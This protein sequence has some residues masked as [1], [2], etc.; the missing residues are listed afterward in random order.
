MNKSNP[1]ES[2]LFTLRN[3]QINNIS[4]CEN[5]KCFIKSQLSNDIVEGPF[6][7]GVLQGNLAVSFRSTED[8][9]EA[10]EQLR[11]G[12]NTTLWCDGM[13][14]GKKKRSHDYDTDN[15]EDIEKKKPKKRKKKEDDREEKVEKLVEGLKA[16]HGTTYTPIQFRIWAEMIAG[17]VHI[18]QDEPPHTTFFNLVL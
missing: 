8:I 5:L 18:S 12:K 15:E 2:K 13:A 1:K 14:S 7:V 6:D 9:K 10:W 3:L 17:G 11:A 16:K 4:S